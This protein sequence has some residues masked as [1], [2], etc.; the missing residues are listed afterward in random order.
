[1]DQ[2]RREFQDTLVHRQICDLETN[3]H[4][5]EGMDRRTL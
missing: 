5:A 3:K 2:I 4:T 1:M